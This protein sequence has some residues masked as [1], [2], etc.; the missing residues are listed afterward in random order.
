[1][2]RITS[3]TEIHLSEV[4]RVQAECY[5]TTM[6]EA[7][8]TLHSRLKAA[9]GSAWV[10]LDAEGICAY[11]FTYPSTTGNITPLGGGFHVP[12]NPD[13]LYLHDLAVAKRAHGQKLGPALVTVALEAAKARGLPYSSLVSVQDSRGFWQRL[14]YEAFGQ[15]D[16]VQRAN[17]RT[18]DG[19]ACYMVK[20][21]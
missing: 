12:E 18:Y 21:L 8:Q 10:A 7:A 20:R 16:D 6:Q 11:L 14:G 15:L 13:C 5:P 17:L 4:L 1:M 3:M 2:Q 19:P 9:P